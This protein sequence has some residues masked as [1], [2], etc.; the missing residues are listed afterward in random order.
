MLTSRSR[1]LVWMLNLLESNMERESSKKVKSILWGTNDL[2]RI[3]AIW[4]WQGFPGGSE[5]QNLLMWEKLHFK[6]KTYQGK[7]KRNKSFQ[8][9]NTTENGNRGKNKIL[10][11]KTR[12]RRKLYLR[13][14]GMVGTRE[15]K[16]RKVVSAKND[17]QG[18]KVQTTLESSSY[19]C[20]WGLE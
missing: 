9:K 13:E 1:S 4:H 15:K 12:P 3:I 14:T 8:E 18:L 19:R 6:G 16:A 10:L 2:G 7:K 5:V 11:N 20:W 17:R